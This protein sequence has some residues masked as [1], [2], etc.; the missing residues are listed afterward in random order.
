MSRQYE[1]PDDPEVFARV[2]E[3]FRN[4]CAAYW[5]AL[6]IARAT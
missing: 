1:F 6:L 4:T 3:H 5:D 2:I